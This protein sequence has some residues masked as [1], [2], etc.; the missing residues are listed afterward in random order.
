MKNNSLVMIAKKPLLSGLFGFSITVSTCI[1]AQTLQNPQ[2]S[3][4]PLQ[5]QGSVEPNLM[6]LIDSSGSM[7]R[8]LDSD[9]DAL[10]AAESRLGVAK[11]A[12]KTFIGELG[13][14][15]VGIAKFNGENGATIMQGLSSLDDASRTTLNSKI[16]DIQPDGKTPLAEA[17][18]DLGRY[19]VEGYEDQQVMPNPDGSASMLTSADILGTGP[20]YTYTNGG[21]NEVTT[22]KPNK[23]VDGTVSGAAIQQYCQKNFILT[24]TDG[25]PNGDSARTTYLEDFDGDGNSDAADALDDVA[26]ALYDIDWRT[27]LQDKNNISSHFIGFASSDVQNSTLL[28]SAAGW[29]HGTYEYADSANSL[30]ASLNNAFSS[31]AGTTGTQSSVAFNS[32]SLDAGSVIYSAQFDTSN[33]S[34]RLYARSLDPQRGRVDRTLWEASEQLGD[35]ADREIITYLGGKGVPFTATA[36]D[37]SSP[38]SDHESDLGFSDSANAPDAAWVDR[39]MYIRGDTSKDGTGTFRQRGTFSRLADASIAGDPKLLGDIVHSTPVY[40]GEPEL[41]WPNYFAN[42]SQSATYYE[43]FRIHN[44]GRTPMVYVGA[45]DGMLHGFNAENGAEVFAYVPSLVLNSSLEQGLH[46]FTDSIYNHNYYVDLTPTVSDVYIDMDGDRKEE[47]STVLI[48]GLRRGGK[49][50]FA[51]NITDPS[52]LAAAETGTN[53]EQIVMWEFD[54]ASGSNDLGYSF[55]EAQVARLNNGR[56]AA[57]FGNGYDSVNGV[58]GLF[59]VYLD[60]GL[61]GWSDADWEFISTEVGP[62]ASGR[63]NGLSSPRLIDLDGDR[64]VDRVYAGDLQGNMW[65]FDLSDQDADIH[66]GD[67]ADQW[68]I[69]GNAPLFTGPNSG[70]PSGAIMAAPLVARNTAVA[71]GAAPNLLVMFGTGQYLNAADL[72][73]NLAGAF[74]AVWDHGRTGITAADLANRELVDGTYGREIGDPATTSTV[75]LNWDNPHQGWRMNL[76]LGNHDAVTLSGYAGER[77]ISAPTLRRNTLFFSTISPSLAPC[78]SSGKGYLMSL[79]FRTGA[80]GD[81]AVADFNNDG[82][83][84]AQDEGYVGMEFTGCIGGNC[85]SDSG[86]SNPGMPGQSGFIG[87]VRCTPGSSGD[88]VCDDIDVGDEPREGRLSWEEFSPR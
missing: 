39:L 24:L 69:A 56:W 10:T 79:D 49:G 71:T 4:V 34:G 70:Q 51:L 17:L 8:E 72:E 80:A 35:N 9:L 37:T 73:D 74:Y 28:Q 5:A 33:F 88:V 16:D 66:G 41:N 62:D 44:E 68:G 3:D 23:N 58:A 36:L 32:T 13:N 26:K 46:A 63:K 54:G 85:S 65:A 31:I 1:S 6:I 81:D 14:V 53:A 27:D 43:Q 64:I 50:Y 61:D 19:F 21:G 15:R 75:A 59:I 38:D 48:G 22:S 25:A 67:D 40:V 20:S 2:L 84:N 77:V 12:A 76:E 29:G 45:N 30:L 52:L 18:A 42:P 60:G 55:S 87:D 78:A 47:W 82:Q 7:K 11:T 86:G 57:I 83:I